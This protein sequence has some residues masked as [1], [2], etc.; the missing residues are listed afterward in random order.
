MGGH[1]TW[2][3]AFTIATSRSYKKNEFPDQNRADPALLARH[4]PVPAEGGTRVPTDSAQT[5]GQKQKP[6]GEIRGR[7]GCPD[8]ADLE[9]GVE[10]GEADGGG[11]LDGAVRLAPAL[12]RRH[13]PSLPP[14]P[15]PL[16]FSLSFGALFATVSRRG[17]FSPSFSS[18]SRRQSIA[19]TRCVWGQSVSLRK[20]EKLGVFVGMEISRGCF[21][22][23]WR[24]SGW[25]FWVV[26][27]MRTEGSRNR[28]FCWRLCYVLRNPSKLLQTCF[29]HRSTLLGSPCRG[30]LHLVYFPTRVRVFF[31]LRRDESTSQTQKS[32]PII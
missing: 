25:V 8:P 31:F 12:H 17:F 28:R 32:H 19:K 14:P 10:V 18:L 22:R 2:L 30:I 29:Q 1:S 3:V 20:R 27:A 7:G 24:T 4:R 23:S 9:V 26:Y 21:L 6:G 5:L 15:L 11:V 13:F 16:S